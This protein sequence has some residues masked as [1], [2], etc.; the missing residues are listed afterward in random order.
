MN[1]DDLKSSYQSISSSGGEKI[2]IDITKKVEDAV[3]RVRIEDKKDMLRVL[4]VLI[5]ASG[6]GLAYAVKGLLNY[7]EHPDGVGYWGYL[8]YVLGI[9]TAVPFL[10]K[11]YR[12]NRSLNYDIPVI[13]FIEETEK[14]FTL[15]PVSKL[16]L[17]PFVLTIDISLVFIASDSRLPTINEVL[18]TQIIMI[19]ALTIGLIIRVLFWRRKLFLLDELRRIKQSL[20]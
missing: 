9:I 11:K 12:H 4:I 17:I 20:K 18:L 6:F 8:L 3:E 16:W 13:Q 10:I 7:L 5:M 2:N 19:F 1:F 15:F 14:R